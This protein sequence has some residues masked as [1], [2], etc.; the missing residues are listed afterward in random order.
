MSG[1]V[2]EVEMQHTPALV[3]VGTLSIYSEST[4]NFEKVGQDAGEGPRTPC[5]PKVE[6]KFELTSLLPSPLLPPAKSAT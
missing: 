1:L 2:G 5:S 4:F 3:S 6:R